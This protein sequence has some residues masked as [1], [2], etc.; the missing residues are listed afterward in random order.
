MF[1]VSFFKWKYVFDQIPDILHF[2][3]TTLLLVAGALIISLL[4]GLLLAVVRVKRIPVLEQ[5]A[6]FYISIVRGT[7]LLV[8]ILLI[9]YSITLALMNWVPG[10]SVASVD[11]RIYGILSL[12]FYQAAYTSEIIRGALESVSRG[13]IEAAQAAGMSYPQTLRRI[14]IPEAIEVAL[15]GLINTLIALFK[16]TSLVFSIGI[17]DM[18]AEAKILA[19]RSF[20]YLE[21]YVALAIIFWVITIIL[22][23][24][25]K[26]VEDSVRI[27]DQA[28]EPKFRGWYAR[29]FRYIKSK[30]KKEVKEVDKPKDLLEEVSLLKKIEELEKNEKIE[31]GEVNVGNQES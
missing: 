8:Q 27:P 30:R 24:I 14:I 11:V 29:L 19:G 16:G 20:R 4:F 26:I 5:L 12:G 3:P 13:E 9:Y 2:F 10:F 21:G 17:I 22:E 6:K 25:G 31:G 1:L 28:E 15:P 7:P 18:Y 23:Q